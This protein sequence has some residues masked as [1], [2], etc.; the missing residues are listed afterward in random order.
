MKRGSDGGAA[1]HSS[2]R[3]MRSRLRSAKD[4]GSRLAR[5]VV[6]QADAIE[7]T[8]GSTP[9]L[10]G[11]YHTPHTSRRGGDSPNPEGLDDTTIIIT[12]TAGGLFEITLSFLDDKWP[13]YVV[14]G[15]NG[16]Y[17]LPALEHAVENVPARWAV[18]LDE[19]AFVL[20][21]AR[22]RDLVAWTAASG[23]AAVGVPDGGVIPRRTH[24][25]NALNLFF[26]IL[27][28]EAIRAVWNPLACRRW[29]GRGSKMTRPWPP[30]P[31]LKPDVPYQFDDYE[32][33]YCFYFWLAEVGLSTAYLDAREHSDGLSVIVLDHEGQPVAIHSW[34]AREFDD[35]GP[36][37]T[38]ILD[39]VDYARGGPDRGERWRGHV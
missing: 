34:Y 7:P 12:S 25:P 23:H 13:V 18:L 24:N 19:D 32:P 1:W 17:G 37:R 10:Q 26:N 36:M 35:E 39:V 15:S 30:A 14:D 3:S 6:R 5:Y 16:C 21:N 33:Y 31:L 9:C 22:L 29:M 28:L 2:N 27:D 4:H 38:R 11:G 8:L 20:D